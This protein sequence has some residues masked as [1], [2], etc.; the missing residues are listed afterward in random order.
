MASP[1]FA[2]TPRNFACL[3]VAPCLSTKP[4]RQA[5]LQRRV[6][7]TNARSSISKET[8]VA[9]FQTL[10]ISRSGKR[11]AG[12]RRDVL[13]WS[14]SAPILG[15]AVELLYGPEYK[16]L[17]AQSSQRSVLNEVSGSIS[18][19]CRGG[20]AIDC[21]CACFPRKRVKVLPASAETIFNIAATRRTFSSPHMAEDGPVL[22]V[23]SLRLPGSVGRP[24]A[25][26]SAGVLAPALVMK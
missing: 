10:G 20:C 2:R 9:L 12:C 17:Q 6:A 15:R 1:L 16:H 13:P 24:R 14:K 26:L 8:E 5:R 25:P 11:C 7:A 4:T 23:S 19:Y 21:F 18:H 22:S 3:P